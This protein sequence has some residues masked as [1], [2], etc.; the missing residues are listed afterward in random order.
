MTAPDAPIFHGTPDQWWEQA[1]VITYAEAADRTLGSWYIMQ[2]TNR[3]E[4]TGAF[5]VAQ[6]SP[7]SNHTRKDELNRLA[8]LGQRDPQAVAPHVRALIR[9]PAARDD[10]MDADLVIADAAVGSDERVAWRRAK[11]QW[12]QVFAGGKSI[13]E[14]RMAELNPIIANISELTSKE[15]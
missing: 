13:S 9:V 2:D 15:G 1:E 12:R 7:H 6:P 3:G 11:G 14:R 5:R 10:W 8:H 4:P